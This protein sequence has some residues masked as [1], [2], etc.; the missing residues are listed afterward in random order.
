MLQ[1]RGEAK[2][3]AKSVSTDAVRRT[4]SSLAKFRFL[5]KIVLEIKTS[6]VLCTE[7]LLCYLAVTAL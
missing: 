3:A 4:T 5:E 7:P 2:M 1:A 6:A